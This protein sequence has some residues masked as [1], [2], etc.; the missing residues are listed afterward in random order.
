METRDSER[1]TEELL[2]LL[3][4]TETP[5][6]QRFKQLVMELE[7]HEILAK[8]F[9]LDGVPYVLKDSPMKYL[10][11]KEQVADRFGVG[12]QDVCIVGSARLGFSPT[13][14][15]YGQDF[16]KASDVD[17]VIISEELFQ[18]GSREL[19][20]EARDFPP[21]LH[22]IREHLR[23]PDGARAPEMAPDNLRRLKEAVRNFTYDNFNPGL[24][25]PGNPLRRRIFDNITSTTGVFLALDPKVFVSRVRCRIFR[26]W[27]AA[28]DYYANALRDLKNYFRHRQPTEFDDS[29]T[30]ETTPEP[31]PI[32]PPRAPEAPPVAPEAPPMQPAVPPAPPVPAP[33][34]DGG[35][36]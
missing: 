16:Q 11:F 35:A 7:A 29:E 33:G 32:A 17:V 31:A 30:E 6:A 5:D 23:D 3:G 27:R 21:P 10:I 20:G 14:Y 4:G 26:T 25:S 8:L 13:P 12:A 34:D 22:E 9:L 18:E 19:F 28:E 24:L 2:K 1:S 15:K 36:G